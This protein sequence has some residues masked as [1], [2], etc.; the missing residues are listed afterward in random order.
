MTIA[1]AV[2]LLVFSRTIASVYAACDP[3]WMSDSWTH[4]PGVTFSTSS[5]ASAGTY[6]KHSVSSSRTDSSLIPRIGNF[7]YADIGNIS[8]NTG[9]RISQSS[10]TD[11]GVLLAI[12][13]PIVPFRAMQCSTADAQTSLY[14]CWTMRQDRQD[15]QLYAYD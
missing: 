2:L 14:W 8:P 12:L 6:L 1:A 15:R 10:S 9:T 4:R 11:L 3:G 13:T 5:T 7:T